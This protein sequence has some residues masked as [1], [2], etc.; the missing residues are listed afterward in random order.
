MASRPLQI[1]FTALTLSLAVSLSLWV[2]HASYEQIQ[3]SRAVT[4]QMPSAPAEINS[5]EVRENLRPVPAS[6]NPFSEI[7]TPP[8]M[9]ELDQLPKLEGI[10]TAPV[11]Q[12]KSADETP[13]AFP[14]VEQLPELTIDPSASNQPIDE[15]PL[16][17]PELSLTEPANDRISELP[18]LEPPSPE[19]PEPPLVELSVE[20][21]AAPRPPAWLSVQATLED[22][23]ERLQQ[24][25][26]TRE[27]ALAK[28]DR[29]TQNWNTKQQNWVKEEA[30]LTEKMLLYRQQL[31]ETQPQ[32]ANSLEE[33]QALQKQLLDERKQVEQLRQLLQQSQAELK[34]TQSESEDLTNSLTAKTEQISSLKDDLRSTRQQISDMLDERN[35]ARSTIPEKRDLVPLTRVAEVPN[36]QRVRPVLPLPDE[37]TSSLRNEVFHQEPVPAPAVPLLAAQPGPPA[38]SQTIQPRTPLIAA[39]IGYGGPNCLEDEPKKKGLIYDLKDWYHDWHDSNDSCTACEPISVRKTSVGPAVSDARETGL[40]PELA[41]FWKDRLTEWD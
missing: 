22:Q 40:I 6:P 34:R 15:Q 28:R 30:A 39:E 3:F 4:L 32:I 13:P 33:K 21:L 35:S 37:S 14:P 1:A 24:Q 17:L 7:D 20:P 19:Q 38:S 26:Q 2:L 9:V 8:Q 29:E 36:P 18:E 10:D 23:I 27:A 5:D 41:R 16:D 25:L 31:A 11:S 12:Q